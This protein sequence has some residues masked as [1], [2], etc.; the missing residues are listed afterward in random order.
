MNLNII[1]DT[2]QYH[3][4][5]TLLDRVSMKMIPASMEKWE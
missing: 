2:A 5:L 3:A 1:I 4:K